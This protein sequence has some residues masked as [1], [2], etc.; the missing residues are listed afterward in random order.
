[1]KSEHRHELKTN[2][3]A[4]W[5]AHFP[6]W[7]QDN[8][9]TLIGAVVGIVLVIAVYFVRFYRKDVVSV[10]Q[11]VQLTGLVTQIPSQKMTSARAASQGTDQSIALLSIGQDLKKFADGSG[12]DRLAALALIKHA[13]T[14]RAEL[15]Y[16]PTAPGSEEGA[17]QIEQAQSSYQA[18]LARAASIPALAATAQFGLGL[19]EEELGNLDK[20]KEIYREVAQK[21]EYDG[22]TAQAAAADRLQTVDDYRGAVTF[23]PAPQPKTEGASAPQVQITPL[24]ATAPS[25]QVF[26][27]PA[28]PEANAPA[29]PE[30]NAPAGN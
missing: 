26:F 17:R 8:R 28:T 30:A 18:A 12:N 15:H 11:H 22:T 2:E 21:A 1:M 10:R 6:Q 4:D 27:A 13:E 20:A 7:I 5:L 25:D 29:V 19:C 23:R 24:D 3:L 14:L 9:S 16:R